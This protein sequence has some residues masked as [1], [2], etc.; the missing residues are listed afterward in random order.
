MKQNL[1]EIVQEYNEWHF[2]KKTDFYLLILFID[3]FLK[4]K[5]RIKNVKEIK[6]NVLKQNCG[7]F[8]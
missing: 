5:R 7:T 2:S 3:F 6:G 4:K 1:K 8:R